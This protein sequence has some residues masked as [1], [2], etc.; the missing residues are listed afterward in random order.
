MHRVRLHLCPLT[1]KARL[2][3]FILNFWLFN[4]SHWTPPPQQVSSGSS[5][6]HHPESIK[7]HEVPLQ[8]SP[9]HPSLPSRGM[10]ENVVSL[11]CML[12]IVFP[13]FF[14]YSSLPSFQG[15]FRSLSFIPAAHSFP[16][17]ALHDI[18]C[19]LQRG[20]TPWASGRCSPPRLGQTLSLAP[21]PRG[22][23]SGDV[24]AGSCSFVGPLDAESTAFT[25][26]R[27]ELQLPGPRR[28]SRWERGC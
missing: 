10:L 4:S 2:T 3:N 22:G 19:P 15:S 23:R 21:P 24:H 13:S 27:L 28:C 14:F 5:S 1:S 26:G 18:M 7:G 20:R 6:A 11:P 17:S 16:P 9:P 12:G 25:P 8:C